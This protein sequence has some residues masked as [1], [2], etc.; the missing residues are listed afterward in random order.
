[1]SSRSLGQA[2]ARPCL[3]A[4]ALR[5]P[6][7]LRHGL[8]VTAYI[9]DV[10]RVE[11][12]ARCV[13][14]LDNLLGREVCPTTHEVGLALRGL[15]RY[16]RPWHGVR[17]GPRL[18]LRGCRLLR[19][20]TPRAVLRERP[21]P[22]PIDQAAREP[23]ASLLP[24]GDHVGRRH[25]RRLLAYEVGLAQ[26]LRGLLGGHV[27]QDQHGRGRTGNAGLFPDVSRRPAGAP[28]FSPRELSRTLRITSFA[29]HTS[30]KILG[31]SPQNPVTKWSGGAPDLAPPRGPTSCA[32][33]AADK[34]AERF[35]QQHDVYRF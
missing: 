9:V 13:G 26:V 25:R 31:P 18:L 33:R 2:I 17:A 24:S 3:R 20:A 10:G 29:P 23:E 11:L 21:A 35:H 1:M 19:S 34:G 12:D 4:R 32:R 7:L 8:V 30:S 16:C 28:G 14:V 15:R 5:R 22:H 6:L 27:R